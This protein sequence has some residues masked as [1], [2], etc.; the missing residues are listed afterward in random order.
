MRTC[1]ACEQK[2]D[3]AEG[4]FKAGTFVCYECAEEM[5]DDDKSVCPECEEP[6]EEYEK[7]GLCPHCG[8]VSED[9]EA[10]DKDKEE[11]DKEEKESE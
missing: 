8:H 1:S 2:M 4:L 10:E 9:E 11:D 7:E 6:S 3:E 5:K